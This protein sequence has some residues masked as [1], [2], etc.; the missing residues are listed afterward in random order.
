MRTSSLGQYRDGFGV[1]RRHQKV[2]GGSYRALRPKTR[3]IKK[4]TGF[5]PPA[6]E[7]FKSANQKSSPG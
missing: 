2:N 5:C 1:F 7:F 6:L 4:P 3:Q